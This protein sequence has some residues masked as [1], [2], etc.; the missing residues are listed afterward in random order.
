MIKALNLDLFY[1]FFQGHLFCYSKSKFPTDLIV[2][3]LI[4]T[5]EILLKK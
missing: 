4:H 3:Y 5:L 2:A 1:N